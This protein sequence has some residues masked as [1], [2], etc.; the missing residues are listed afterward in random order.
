MARLTPG[1][2]A[3]IGPAAMRLAAAEGLQAHGESVR[4]RLLTLNERVPG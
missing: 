3:A 4:A 1:A 2:L